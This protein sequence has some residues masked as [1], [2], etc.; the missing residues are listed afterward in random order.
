[1]IKY[2][3]NCIVVQGPT[4]LSNVEM[5]KKCWKDYNII[6]STWVDSDKSCYDDGDIVIYSEY[7]ERE[8]VRGGTMNINYQKVSTL[9][10]LLKAKE[11]G[12]KRVVKWRSDFYPNNSDKLMKLF[13]DECLNLYSFQKYHLEGYVT[14][15][16][17]EGKVDDV[18]NLWNWDFDPNYPEWGITKHMY[19]FGLDSKANFIC[20]QLVKDDVDIFWNGTGA[21][22]Y[23]L[24]VNSKY[25]GYAD[26]LPETMH[27]NYK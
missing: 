18:I 10:G 7:P 20:K 22:N 5:I 1:M 24:S 8:S 13:K 17:M 15:F 16:F 11:L 21:R 9:N 14:D 26:K 27:I 25:E 12:F 23:W 19:K 2:K 3:D 6:F 4:K